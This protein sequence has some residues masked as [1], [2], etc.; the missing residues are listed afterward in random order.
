MEEFNRGVK[1]DIYAEKGWQKTIYWVENWDQSLC[2]SS[3]SL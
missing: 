2:Q 3:N 1:E